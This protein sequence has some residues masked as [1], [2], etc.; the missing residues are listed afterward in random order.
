MGESIKKNSQKQRKFCLDS[1]LEKKNKIKK[2][3]ERKKRREN[4]Q[5]NYRTKTILSPLIIH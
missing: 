1:N 5:F 3:G 4:L 2:T